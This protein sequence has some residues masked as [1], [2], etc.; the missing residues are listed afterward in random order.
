[1][2]VPKGVT[3]EELKQC[4]SRSDLSENAF[5]NRLYLCRSCIVHFRVFRTHQTLAP[6]IVARTPLFSKSS[7]NEKE[8]VVEPSSSYPIA[9]NPVRYAY[10]AM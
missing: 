5:E 8:V 4:F 6:A 7:R 10:H 9:W 3:V 2:V 1:V